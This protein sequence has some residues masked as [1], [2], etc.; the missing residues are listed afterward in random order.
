MRRAL[1]IIRA[2]SAADAAPATD[3]VTLDFDARHR[4]RLRMDADSGVPVILDLPRATV[5]RDGDLLV[6][7]D[8]S[9]IA[10]RAAAEE[11]L[12]I[13]CSDTPALMRMAWHLGNRHLPTDISPDRLLIRR[14]HVIAD[15]A[16]GLGGAV[17]E[18]RAPFDP[19][20]GAYDEGHHHAPADGAQDGG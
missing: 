7:E 4:R 3:S 6:C 5:L 9:H 2:D 15:M 19:E 18:V 20:G 14:D 12:E 11:L 1:S 17:R 10:V 13:R 8:G 16:A